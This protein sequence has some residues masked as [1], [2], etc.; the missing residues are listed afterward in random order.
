[1]GIFDL[2][3][4]INNVNGIS[5]QEELLNEEI[6]NF[7]T[8]LYNSPNY[9]EV[10]KYGYSDKMDCTIQDMSFNNKTNGD[11]KILCVR[12]NEAL[13]MGDTLEWNG[14][15]WLIILEEINTIQSH[16]TF[17][18]R[19][20]NYTLKWLNEQGKLISCPCITTNATMY[21]LG[22]NTDTNA[23]NTV[24]GKLSIIL[25]YNKDT[26]WIKRDKRFLFHNSAYKVTF[27]DLTQINSVNMTGTISF[28]LSECEL[29][30]TTDNL[31]LGIA[32]YYN[33]PKYE[34]Q[35]KEDNIS[36]S[37]ENTL[38]LNTI[39]TKDG[40]VIDNSIDKLELIWESDNPTVASV[41][42]NGLV[43]AIISG[44]A[45]ITV[46]LRDNENIK[47]TVLCNVRNVPV[48]NTEYL[49]EGDSSITWTVAKEYKAIKLINGVEQSV[50][51]NF[52]IDYLGNDSKIVTM[53]TTG[54][55]TVKIQANALQMK[56]RIKL[57]S[58]NKLNTSEVIEKQIEIKGF[59]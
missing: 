49:I 15:Q 40:Q 1:M 46:K 14:K 23:P 41:D 51:W 57:I 2:Y 16:K 34:I 22:I 58:R 25:P 11:E 4:K 50:A 5:I 43:T 24:D 28:V 53:T 9:Y 54:I 30:N 12:S 48:I 32:D 36:I 59:Y 3:R 21:S 13:N 44:N 8:Y 6:E 52:S 38:Q 42:S 7:E 29:N 45:N 17:I 18:I 33:A 35:I 20:C 39:I 19:P 10:N 37:K 47:D 31:E 26:S 55:N 56:G 27:P